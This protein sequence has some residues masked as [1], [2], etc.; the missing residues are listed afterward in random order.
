MIMRSTEMRSLREIMRVALRDHVRRFNIRKERK[1]QDIVPFAKWRTR[2]MQI[3]WN[4]TRQN[5]AEYTSPSPDKK[6]KQ[7]E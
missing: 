1:V 4:K 3:E 6:Q 2:H 7:V 5:R